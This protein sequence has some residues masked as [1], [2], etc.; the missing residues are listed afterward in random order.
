MYTTLKCAWHTKNGVL[1]GTLDTLFSV[2]SFL[3]LV[4]ND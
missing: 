3:N 2:L 4:C 1:I